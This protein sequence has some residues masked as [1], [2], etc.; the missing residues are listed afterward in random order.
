MQQQFQRAVRNQDTYRNKSTVLDLSTEEITSFCVQDHGVQ[1]H[2]I[3][4][5]A[6]ITYDDND[7]IVESGETVNIPRSKYRVIVSS[8]N[9][10]KTIRYQIA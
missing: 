4:G 2:L 9:K 5:R 7:V 8:A 10:Y 1:F 3:E 6:W